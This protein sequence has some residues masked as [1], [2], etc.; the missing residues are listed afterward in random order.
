MPVTTLSLNGFST[1]TLLPT[2]HELLRTRTISWYTLYISKW[3]FYGFRFVRGLNN[4]VKHLA[5]FRTVK[6]LD[7]VV[8]WLQETRLPPNPLPCFP[9]WMFSNQ[10]HSTHS[11]YSRGVGIL[12]HPGTRFSCS[13]SAIDPEGCF[14]LLLCNISGLSCIIAG[15]YI[16]LLFS[17]VV[18]K[19]LA[20]FMVRFPDLLLLAVSDFYHISG[21]MTFFILNWKRNPWK[22][23]FVRRLGGPQSYKVITP[24]KT[25]AWLEAQCMFR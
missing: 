11:S 8:I 19:S 2:Q 9:S 21:H 16:P 4:P 7:A 1:V 12:I 14:V 13:Q 15:V 10:F 24:M 20:S 17:F 6:Q 25:W 5:V 23:L 3:F 22:H 18:L